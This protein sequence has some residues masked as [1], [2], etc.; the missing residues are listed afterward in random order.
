MLS[1]LTYTMRRILPVLSPPRPPLS[2]QAYLVENV[3]VYGERKPEQ[4]S[5]FITLCTLTSVCIFSSLFSKHFLRCRGGEFFQQS[6]ASL[7]GGHFLYHPDLNVW[8]R[9][10][11]W[12]VFRCWSLLEVKDL[13]QTDIWI[14]KGRGNTR[15]SEIN[16]TKQKTAK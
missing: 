3:A 8:F 1:R 10:D 4:F 6:R 16:I 12:G 9:D 14:K 15:R 13:N 2:K 7:V 11:L 5:I